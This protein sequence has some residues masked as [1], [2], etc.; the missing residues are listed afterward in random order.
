MF[1]TGA[2]NPWDRADL[3]AANMYS[4]KLAVL[5]SVPL[6]RRLEATVSTDRQLEYTP[7]YL[8]TY[9]PTIKRLPRECATRV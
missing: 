9:R 8:K 4:T 1:H 3:Q 5:Y 7:T 6:S 2:H